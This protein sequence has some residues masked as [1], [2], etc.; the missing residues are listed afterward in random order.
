MFM[1]SYAEQIGAS[2][3][4]FISLGLLAAVWCM[5]YMALRSLAYVATTAAVLL[6]FAEWKWT[7]KRLPKV[8]WVWI[9][10]IGLYPILFATDFWVC[11]NWFKHQWAWT[12][13]LPLLGVISGAICYARSQSIVFFGTAFLFPIVLHLGLGIR[14]ALITQA[15][16]YNF[17]GIHKHHDY[18]GCAGTYS[19]A[20]LGPLLILGSARWLK[21]LGFGAIFLSVCSTILACSRT[22]LAFVAL[23]SAASILIPT[24]LLA[25]ERARGR[26]LFFGA[27]LTLIFFLGA[28]IL[29]FVHDKERWGKMSSR[30]AEGFHGDALQIIGAGPSVDGDTMRVLGA[31]AGLVLTKAQPWGINGSNSAYADALHK[32]YPDP[33]NALDHSHNGWV[34][35]C[36]AIGYLGAGL[37]FLFFQ[38]FALEG[39][40]ALSDSRVA[41]RSAAI[42][43]LVLSEISVVRG[44]FDSVYRDHYLQMQSFT[45]PFLFGF[46]LASKKIDK[47]TFQVK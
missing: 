47:N 35:T 11:L 12:I 37:Y 13:V 29:S 33:V 2:R 7:V 31:R 22:G 18:Y 41:V 1:K 23:T 8:V 4:M 44:L 40:A 17:W 21:C 16:P 6:S 28:G 27:V 19:I 38:S 15:L 32:V 46:L 43:L 42:S 34:D 20:I 5:P 3:L 24:C 36:L 39:F 14:Q 26:I 30:I 25:R 9:F 45:L 10:F